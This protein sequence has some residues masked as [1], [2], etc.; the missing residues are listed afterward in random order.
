MAS[1]NKYNIFVQ[2]LCEAKHA[3]GTTVTRGAT[4]AD[5][6]KIM[7]TNTAPSASADTTYSGISANEL[8][9]GNGYTTGGVTC[10]ISS[11]SQT[12]GTEKVVLS[13]SSPTWTASGSMGP[14][15]YV[16]LYNSTQGGL[17]AWWDFGSSLTMAATDTFTVTFDAVNGVFQLA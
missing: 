16:V 13:V 15:R 7:L 8:A 14:F 17:V 6:Y 10:T 5:T 4:T 11:E 12:S 9:N 2:A 3:F 1:Y